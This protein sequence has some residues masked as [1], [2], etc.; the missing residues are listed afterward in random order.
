MHYKAKHRFADVTARKMR[1]FAQMVRGMNI[2]VALEALRFHPNRG[3][4]HIEAVIKSA[5]GNAED[6]GCRNI[7]E[8]VV[9]EI[10]IDDGPMY[11]RIQPRARGTA[12]GIL[13]RLAHIR[14]TLTDLEAVAEAEA[15]AAAA[16]E[17][18]ATETPA[19]TAAQP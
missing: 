6:K 10:C 18:P 9:S 2:D 1:P 13:K 11:K 7:D 12:F 4:R 17:T 3:C 19:E 15:A 14:V 8:L 16:N 5:L